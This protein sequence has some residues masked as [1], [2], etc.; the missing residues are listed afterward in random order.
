MQTVDSFLLNVVR[1]NQK[2]IV[3][4]IERYKEGFFRKKE[5]SVNAVCHLLQLDHIL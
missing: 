1:F 3:H 5:I 4:G 2:K